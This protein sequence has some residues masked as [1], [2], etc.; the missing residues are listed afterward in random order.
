MAVGQPKIE[1]SDIREKARRNLQLAK[2]FGARFEGRLKELND[3]SGKRGE[4]KDG[5]GA[6]HNAIAHSADSAGQYLTDVA[7]YLETNLSGNKETN[8][9]VRSLANEL[10]ALKGE[11]ETEWK[12]EGAT[13]DGYDPKKALAKIRGLF[14][15]LRQVNL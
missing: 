14:E 8:R 11:I 5:M 2:D 4:G 3:E 12:T 6:I 7:D 10:K 15:R 13:P 9:E 1:G